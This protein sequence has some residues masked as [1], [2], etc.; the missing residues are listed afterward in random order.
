MHFS[1]R[2]NSSTVALNN[3]KQKISINI[4]YEKF[5]LDFF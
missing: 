3:T 4:Y 5:V 2:N 1:L